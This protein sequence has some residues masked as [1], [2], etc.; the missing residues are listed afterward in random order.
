MA[1]IPLFEFF[2]GIVDL[3]QLAGRAANGGVDAAE[4]RCVAEHRINRAARLFA[5]LSFRNIRHGLDDAQAFLQ[6]V[7]E[8]FLFGAQV[9]NKGPVRLLLALLFLEGVDGVE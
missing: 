1:G 4:F 9:G 8:L 3:H 7:G 5:A 2:L 6:L